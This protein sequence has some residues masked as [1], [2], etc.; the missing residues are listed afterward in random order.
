MCRIG[1]HAMLL[2]AALAVTACTRRN[3]LEPGSAAMIVPGTEDAAEDR[4]EGVRVVT[5]TQAWQG[6]PDIL[7]DVTPVWVE[8]TNDGDNPIAVR[9]S[10]FQ[11]V[12][13]DGTEYAALPPFATPGSASIP[14]PYYGAG[15]YPGYWGV[16]YYA[17]QP[18]GAYPY[19]SYAY[20]YVPYDY[21][22][23]G[24][25]A[26][27][28]LPTPDMVGL[29]LPEDTV[30]PG[31]QAAGFVY[32]QRVDDDEVAVDFRYTLTDAEEGEQFAQAAIPFYVDDFP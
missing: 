8:I 31:E 10:D 18:V 2:V 7:D 14:V 17:P 32:F 12:A 15:A 3:P 25:W 9:Y 23:Y 22:Y 27:V 21:Y 13:V 26:E 16:P 19:D 20:G 24:G 29:A 1:R 11:L 6:T 28:P 5:R 30:E 4:V